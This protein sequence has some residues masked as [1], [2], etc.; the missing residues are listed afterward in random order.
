MKIF[1]LKPPWKTPKSPEIDSSS[2]ENKK[3]KRIYEG[4]SPANTWKAVRYWSVSG[5][6]DSG[7]I[8]TSEQY[9]YCHA[10]L[11]GEKQEALERVWTA[12]HLND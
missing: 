1:G 6:E 7:S 5:L 11:S 12:S 10:L 9:R 2:E 4:M 3:L 8:L